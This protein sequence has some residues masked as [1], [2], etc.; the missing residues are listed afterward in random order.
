MFKK[1]VTVYNFF[2]KKKNKRKL[3]LT[4][5]ITILS[6]IFETLSILSVGPLVQILSDPNSINNEDQLVSKVYN[7]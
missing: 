5:F 7:F 1:L 2:N 3:L 4:Q 6:S